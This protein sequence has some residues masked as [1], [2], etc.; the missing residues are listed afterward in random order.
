MK[1]DKRNKTN[2]IVFLIFSVICVCA[3]VFCLIRPRGRYICL[4]LIFIFCWAISFIPV[5]P[6]F[7]RK[8][9]DKS[10]NTKRQTFPIIAYLPIF[11][12]LY[13]ICFLN[14]FPIAYLFEI[15]FCT[16]WP[17]E[18][19]GEIYQ[20]RE[21]IGYNGQTVYPDGLY[22]FP[23]ELPENAK[24]VE[25]KYLTG[26]MQDKGYRSLSFV[27]DEDYIQNY[28]RIQT[29]NFYERV[30]EYFGGSLT[31]EFRQDSRL[32]PQNYNFELDR[33][34]SPAPS[35]LSFTQ[36]ELAHAVQ[37][38]FG[39]FDYYEYGVIIV[40]NTNRIVIYHFRQ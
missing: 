37:Y 3:I 25:W 17:W 22:L 33:W 11:G 39:F 4:T 5:R 40:E 21:E 6:F 14:L 38:D 32:M 8:N 12:V 36:E 28:M 31:E 16:R 29:E 13:F 9:T 24:N 19:P 23:E 35:E 15:F 27:A 2:Y 20:L 26:Y 30:D 18:Y 34:P 7:K 10:T 1:I